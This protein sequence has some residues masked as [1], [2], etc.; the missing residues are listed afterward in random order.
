[1]AK[2][3][4]DLR[5]MQR[6]QLKQVTK[7]ELIDSILASG[8]EEG[9]FK[10]L[11]DKL[12]VVMAEVAEMKKANTSAESSLTKKFTELQTQIDKQAEIISTQQRF[13]E[14]IDRKEREANIVVLGVPDEGEALDGA[15]TDAEKLGKIWEKIDVGG[16]ACTHHRLGRD[17]DVTYT[18]R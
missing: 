17:A 18:T 8:E 6:N 16:V 5:K 13:L 12:G 4:C 1:M 10:A 9:S 3:L 2:R 15:V 11:N 7:D 14:M